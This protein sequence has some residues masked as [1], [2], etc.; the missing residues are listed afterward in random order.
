MAS[1][2]YLLKMALEELWQ[3]HERNQIPSEIRNHPSQDA[4]KAL[5]FRG[6]YRDYGNF[7]GSLVMFMLL[8]PGDFLNPNEASLSVLPLVNGAGDREEV[9]R[10]EGKS[11][12]K[13]GT[14][15]N[16]NRTN[17]LEA[18]IGA[19][20]EDAKYTQ[21]LWECVC[22]RCIEDE[23]SWVLPQRDFIRRIIDDYSHVSNGVLQ[24]AS[25]RTCTELNIDPYNYY[26]LVKKIG[27]ILETGR[28]ATAFLDYSS[29]MTLTGCSKNASRQL[30]EAIPVLQDR[31]HQE[32]NG[33]PR[34]CSSDTDSSCNVQEMD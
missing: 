16:N 31:L 14:G 3:A 12:Q 32:S 17:L 19:L 29:I 34:D 21:L 20:G 7:A 24:L 26:P 25:L 4:A 13:S 28:G 5:A 2:Q 27:E 6:F 30:W 18:I 9:L 33:E 11:I 15:Q 23:E 10:E 1:L 22:I 8:F